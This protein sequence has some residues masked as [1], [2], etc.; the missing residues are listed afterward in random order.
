MSDIV[1]YYACRA[2]EYE[3]IYRKPKRQADLH[4]LHGMIAD[5]FRGQDVL[6]IACG[7]GYWTTTIV[8]TARSILATDLNEEMLAIAS[9][10]PY[11]ADVVRFLRT[12]AYN[13]YEVCGSFS[14][15]LAA[16]WWSHIPKAQ[17]RDFL[18]NSHKKLR[19]GS[20]VVFI[21]NVYA[22][23]SSSPMADRVDQDGNTYGR[24]RL[25]DG[26][27]WE[28][29]KNFPSEEE[30]RLSLDGLAEDLCYIPLTY[31]WWLSYRTKV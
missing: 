2:D 5:S 28:I 7:T 3:E 23:G 14:A 20:L 9:R 4:T 24:R 16:F 19:P 6:E 26:T 22:E 17:L 13:L 29:L 10:K 25:S 21:D 15:A 1:R 27:E 18:I 31:Y 30:I 12:D 11:P 8:S